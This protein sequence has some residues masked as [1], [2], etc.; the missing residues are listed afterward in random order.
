MDEHIAAIDFKKRK[1][2]KTL[3]GQMRQHGRNPSL[4]LTECIIPTEK[5][6]VV[7]CFY[8]T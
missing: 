3:H 6:S 2:T 7:L 5:S 4:I 8:C 1:E